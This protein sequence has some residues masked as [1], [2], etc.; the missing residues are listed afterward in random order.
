[1][2]AGD[3]T[4]N[5]CRFDATRAIALY[6]AKAGEQV[7]VQ[8]LGKVL[9][10]V[11]AFGFAVY[12]HVQAQFFLHINGQSN[13]LLH[14]LLVLFFV[15]L[16]LAQALTGGADIGSL[17]E[18]T[19]GGGREQRQVQALTLQLDA[20]GKGCGTLAVFGRYR[21]QTRLHLR[22]VNTGR[23]G[24][25]VLYLA[26]LLQCSLHYGAIRVVD[27]FG[28]NRHFFALL[29]GKRQPAFQLV[30]QLVFTGQVHRAVQQ[31]AGRRH[32]QAITKTLVG[33]LQRFED[34]FQIGAPDVTAIDHT[35]RQHLIGRQAVKDG[36]VLFRCTH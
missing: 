22:L 7:A 13:L 27:G 36:R 24:T 35:Q 3:V 14:G 2:R 9:D 15:Q 8:L 4:V 16:A 20:L 28:Q 18:G 5:H 1:M 11:V 19:N 23:A 12:Q 34:F 10:H 31:R 17:R 30:I 26:A 33:V 29:Y 21:R 32:P 25:A 6:P